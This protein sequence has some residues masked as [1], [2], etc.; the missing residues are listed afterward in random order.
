MCYLISSKIGDCTKQK[1][2]LIFQLFFQL[3][4]IKNYQKSTSMITEMLNCYNMSKVL[5]LINL[6][7]VKI[8][9]P[10]FQCSTV[11]EK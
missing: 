6:V 2:R 5:A 11:T 8:I 3:E 1:D 7:Q 9:S 10:F 4:K